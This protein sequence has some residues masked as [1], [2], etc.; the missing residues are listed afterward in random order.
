MLS[1]IF[2]LDHI[3]GVIMAFRNASL[4]PFMTLSTFFKQRIFQTAQWWRRL[5]AASAPEFGLSSDLLEDQRQATA[6]HARKIGALA[7]TK[8]HER[9]RSTRVR[10][11]P[12]SEPLHAAEHILID[13]M[14]QFDRKAL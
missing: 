5:G 1:A 4:D 3:F 2:F 8:P 13:R 11:T 9:K 10:K 7:W 14:T 12:E 6:R